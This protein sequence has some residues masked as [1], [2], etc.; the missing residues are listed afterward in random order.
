METEWTCRSC[1]CVCVWVRVCACVHACVQGSGHGVHSAYTQRGTYKLTLLL[2]SF[3]QVYEY[4]NWYRVLLRTCKHV[5][6]HC[7]PG[8]I[9]AEQNGDLF[10]INCQRQL[11]HSGYVFLTVTKH[12][13]DWVRSSS[14]CLTTCL[15]VRT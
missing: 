5:C 15:S 7:F 12:L 4:V 14:T 9:G 10:F 8:T 13:D 3:I 6:Q 1:A 11:V 2:N